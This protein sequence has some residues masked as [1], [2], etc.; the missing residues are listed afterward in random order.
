MSHQLTQVC[1]TINPPITTDTYSI[2]ANSC[3]NCYSQDARKPLREVLTSSSF[4]LRCTRIVLLCAMTRGS[5]GLSAGKQALNQ[6]SFRGTSVSRSWPSCCTKHSSTGWL[7]AVMT[8]LGCAT[9]HTAVTAARS[10]ADSTIVR[11]SSY[12]L[13]HSSK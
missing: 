9:L 13:R 6:S 1:Y 5:R 3:S 4:L 7:T 11:A 2:I 8:T 12:L 10:P